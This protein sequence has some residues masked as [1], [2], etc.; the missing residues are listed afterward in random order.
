MELVQGGAPPVGC[1]RWFINPMHTIDI[2]P[3]HQPKRDIVLINQLNA[4]ELGHHLVGTSNQSL[5]SKRFCFAT[6]LATRGETC[7]FNEFVYGGNIGDSW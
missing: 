2:N 1:E 7:Q 5:S 4:K 3:I 6:E